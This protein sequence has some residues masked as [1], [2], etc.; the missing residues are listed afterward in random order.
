MINPYAEHVTEPMWRL[1][2]D[3]S[4]HNPKAKLSG[5]Y[6]NKSGYHNKRSSIPMS[7]YSSGRDVANDRLGPSTKASAIDITLDE[8]DMKLYSKRL[9]DAC[10][11][12]DARL[13]INGEPIIREFIGTLDGKTVYCYVLTGGKAL[14]V[15]A[16][17]GPDP[18]R[19]KSHLW[20]LH[21]SIIRKFMDNEK[22]MRNLLSILTATPEV[23]MYPESSMR[24]FPWQYNGRGMPGVPD[25]HSTL[26]A[27]GTTYSNTEDTL[28][29]VKKLEE[30]VKSLL[31]T[32]PGTVIITDEQLERVIR[33]VIGSVDNV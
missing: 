33:K 25:G 2:V 28:E 9:A 30:D 10:K 23:K 26:W 4:A 24:A 8:A 32:P 21:I 12:K 29:R 3:F 6:A 14:G 16:D 15:G 13:Y 18:G 20:H 27:L 17:S 7:D 31:Q 11:K 22:A 1:W 19:D 5:F